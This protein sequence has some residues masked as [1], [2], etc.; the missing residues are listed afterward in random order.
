[1][2]EVVQSTPPQPNPA[3]PGTG[4]FAAI[5]QHFEKHGTIYLIILGAAGLFVAVLVWQNNQG[6]G[7]VPVGG[8]TAGTNPV[9]TTANQADLNSI[10]AGIEGIQTQLG[11]QI[12]GGAGLNGAPVPRGPLSYRTT[13]N[14]SIQWLANHFGYTVAQF[15]KLPGVWSAIVGQ[16]GRW[17]VIPKNQEITLPVGPGGIGAPI[18]PLPKTSAQIASQ[19]LQP[20]TAGMLRTS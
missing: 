18:N 12:G 16:S 20:K 10:L 13:G 8:G 5:R 17:S 9:D 6:G 19:A 2:T 14:E 1:M 7:I 3:Q 15:E 11:Q 4:P